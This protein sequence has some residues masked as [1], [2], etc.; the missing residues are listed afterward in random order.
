[1]CSRNP[2]IYEPHKSQDSG[3][4]NILRGQFS[5]LIDVTVDLLEAPAFLLMLSP[6]GLFLSFRIKIMYFRFSLFMENVIR[7][8]YSPL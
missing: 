8:I 7:P 3:Q 1:M 6:Q 2:Y 4:P 5:P